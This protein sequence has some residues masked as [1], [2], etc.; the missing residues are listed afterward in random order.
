MAATTSCV[1]YFRNPLAEIWDGGH[2]E[3]RIVW[4]SGIAM[5]EK[6]EWRWSPRISEY[7]LS[8][9]WRC[10][11]I[12]WSSIWCRQRAGTEPAPTVWYRYAQGRQ[13]GPTQAYLVWNKEYIDGLVQDCSISSAL[14]LEIL[15]SCTEPSIYAGKIRGYAGKFVNVKM[16]LVVTQPGP[17]FNIKIPSYQ[18]RKFHCGDK[19]VV[20]SSYLHNGISYTCKMTSLYW[21]R[22]QDKWVIGNY[23][24]EGFQLPLSLQRGEMTWLNFACSANVVNTLGKWPQ[25]CVS[26]L[27][28]FVFRFKVII[29]L[30]NDLMLIRRHYLKQ[31]SLTSY[32]LNESYTYLSIYRKISIISRTKS[33][34]L[35]VSR[36]VLQLSLANPMKSGVKSR[37]KM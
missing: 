37:M 27:K 30:A 3:I 4:I 6:S 35:I 17:W 8:R 13:T 31:W 18:Y 14:A 29:S 10:L 20:R 2:N 22:A 33:Q 11:S 25:K 9:M 34:N 23:H 1:R 26:W 7:L 12:G 21:I 32:G 28:N 15:Q 16:I 19:T 5:V 24:R 36:L